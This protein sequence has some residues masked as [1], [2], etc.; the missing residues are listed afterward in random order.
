MPKKTTEETQAEQSARFR[1]EAQRLIDAGELSLIEA[2]QRLD[3]LTKRA[4]TSSPP[5]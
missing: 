4:K 5:D 2:E 3:A 1:K